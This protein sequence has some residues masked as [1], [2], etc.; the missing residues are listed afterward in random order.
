MSDFFHMMLCQVVT[1][2]TWGDFAAECELAGIR[3][4]HL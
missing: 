2:I 1:Y 3:V 4:Q